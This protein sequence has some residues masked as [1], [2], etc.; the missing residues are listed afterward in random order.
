MVSLQSVNMLTAYRMLLW[1]TIH[2]TS[3]SLTFDLEANLGGEYEDYWDRWEREQD[4][5]WWEDGEVDLR[6]EDDMIPE[7]NEASPEVTMDQSMVTDSFITENTREII[8]N[9][10][11]DYGQFVYRNQLAKIGAY[12]G[13]SGKGKVDVGNSFE[14]TEIYGNSIAAVDVEETSVSDVTMGALPLY[15]RY[16]TGH[17]LT[18]GVP[19]DHTTQVDIKLALNTLQK[20]TTENFNVS[21]KRGKM[22]LS[23]YSA[24][25]HVNILHAAFYQD[26]TLRTFAFYITNL[27]RD[28]N[29]TGNSNNFHW[30]T[31]IYTSNI[32][33]NIMD[34]RWQRCVGSDRSSSYI[35]M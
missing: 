33:L 35:C 13:D 28:S 11:V 2:V 4:E 31:R 5:Q 22:L 32:I 23:Y 21:K 14:S 17:D 8:S 1:L 26:V 12:G 18:T 6:G 7:I 3:R 16:G 19:L 29:G 30:Q 15:N 9:Q 20:N 24:N 10:E 27:H 34:P 25:S